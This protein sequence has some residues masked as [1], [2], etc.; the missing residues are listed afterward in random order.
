MRARGIIA[1]IALLLAACAHASPAAEG[2][3]RAVAQVMIAAL[4]DPSLEGRRW[5][6]LIA[7]LS[8]AV[9]WQAALDESTKRTGRIEEGGRISVSAEGAQDR[10]TTLT[11]AVE[12]FTTLALLE[13]LRAEGA[14]VSFQADY[15]SY[16]EY[17]VNAPGR[18]PALLTSASTCSPLEERPTIE[19]R[20]TAI[21]AFEAF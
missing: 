14:D 13:A 19:C 21:L 2:D 10:V 11:F 7:R 12:G 18:E 15:E 20:E 6:V 16:S 3:E 1:A 17:V 9:R 8:P 4:A 5:E